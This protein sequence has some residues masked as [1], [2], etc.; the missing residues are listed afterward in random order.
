[1]YENSSMDKTF[2]TD[3]TQPNSLSLSPQK[4]ISRVLEGIAVTSSLAHDKNYSQIVKSINQFLADL[5]AAL[6]PRNERYFELFGSVR[7]RMGLM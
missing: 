5:N 4:D 3:G 7:S 6:F 2:S 1:M